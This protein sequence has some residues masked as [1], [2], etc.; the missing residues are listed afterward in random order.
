MYGAFREKP[1]LPGHEDRGSDKGIVI[2]EGKVP[3]EDRGVRGEYMT[4]VK[5]CLRGGQE[6][7][8][9]R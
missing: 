5:G 9:L 1:E 8:A 3:S 7:L 6:G 4:G 2:K